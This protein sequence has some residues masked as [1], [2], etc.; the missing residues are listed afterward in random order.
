MSE[1][2]KR[3]VKQAA[4]TVNNQP[5]ELPKGTITGLAIKEAA[6]A[7][8]VLIQLSFQLSVRRGPRQTQIIGD[9]EVIDVHDGLEFVAV[10]GDDNS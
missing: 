5:V 1:E 7:Q 10:A 9:N 2:L 8:H 3:P 6:I 4:V